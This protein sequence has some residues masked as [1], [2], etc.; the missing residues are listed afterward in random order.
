MHKKFCTVDE[1]KNHSFKKNIWFSHIE[2]MV[3]VCRYKFAG[4]IGFDDFRNYLAKNSA[5]K[6]AKKIKFHMW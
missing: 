3:V 6:K 1:K 4:V 5:R 2:Q